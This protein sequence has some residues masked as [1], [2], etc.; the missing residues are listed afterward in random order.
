MSRLDAGDYEEAIV[1]LE[2]AADAAP[3]SLD[4]L[5]YLGQAYL[6][7]EDYDNSRRYFDIV[8]QADD[9]F[10]PAY[11]GRALTFLG[12]D[13]EL[14]VSA[15]FYKAVYLAPEYIDARLAWAEHK[16]DSGEYDEAL[17]DL[18]IAFEIDPENP[19]TY[20]LYTRI[21]I[22]ENLP[23][24]ALEAAQEA[25]NRDLLTIEN[26]L[27][28]S[29]ALILNDLHPQA[30]PLLETYLS[31]AEEDYFA[32]Y[33]LGRA[34]LGIGN[35][36]AALDI[37]E[38]TYAERRNIYEMSYY[39][40]LALIEVEEYTH[41]ADRLLVPIQRIPRWYEP[42]VAQAEAYFMDEQYNLAKEVLEVG[43]DRAISDEQKAALYYWRG[44]IYTELGYPGIAETSWENL[45]EL[46]PTAVP[47]EWWSAAQNSLGTSAPAR[48]APAATPTRVPTATSTP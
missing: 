10:A 13:P 41:A 36:Q 42:H 32:W 25:F 39:W 26:Y 48:T 16:I 8:I 23:E 38:Y 21:Y 14:N 29:H 45:L 30:I 17:E 33:L 46:P 15:D 35:T 9:T 44:L 22:I 4:I 1:F 12:M 28:L 19:H 37:F 7:N 24:E 6:L 40:G 31:H 43:A 47:A 3:G 20:R 27:Q 34:N 5:Y 2:Q 11:V 18:A